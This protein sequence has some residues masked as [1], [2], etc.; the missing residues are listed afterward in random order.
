[1]G[2]G[3]DVGGML[4]GCE[5]YVEWFECAAIVMLYDVFVLEKIMVV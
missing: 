2:R 3:R 1:M 5:D 4:T